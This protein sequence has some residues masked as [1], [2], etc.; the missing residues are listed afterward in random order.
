[1]QTGNLPAG[2]PKPTETLG[3]QIIRWAQKFIVQPDGDRAGEPW[4]FTPEQL[5]FVLWLYAINPDGSW[6]YSAATLRRAKGWGKTPLLAALA[7]VEFLGPARF[8]RWDAFGL[9]VGKPVPLPVVQVGATAL[10]Q[11][12]QTLDMIRGML[13]ESPAEA[14]YGL[15]IGKMVVQFKSGKPGSIKPKATAGRT[16]EGNR[17]TFVQAPVDS[18]CWGLDIA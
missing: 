8:S 5:R 11:T 15:D 3:Y 1:M 10:D 17:P 2:V 7:I 9:P 14:I 4:Q 16:N 6:R 12:E 13:S 18:F